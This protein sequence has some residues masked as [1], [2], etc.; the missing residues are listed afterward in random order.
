MGHF[1]IMFCNVDNL[2]DFMCFVVLLLLILC[3][4]KWFFSCSGIVVAGLF[5]FVGRVEVRRLVAD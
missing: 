2:N 3:I 4:Y 1:K 5:G